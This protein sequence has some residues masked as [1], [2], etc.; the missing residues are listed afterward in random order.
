MLRKTRVTLVLLVL[1]LL[2][3]STGT[4]KIFSN[5]KI[6]SL[7]NQDRAKAGLKPLQLNPVLNLAAQAKAYDMLK[8]NYFD[9]A[10]PD[11]RLP[12]AWFKSMGYDYTYAGE[13][14]A[15]GFSNFNEMEDSLMASA[16]HRANILS[17]L[18]SDLGVGI[19]EYRGSPI[20]VQFF[21]ST[22]N[23]LT[24]RQ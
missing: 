14:L 6:L 20:V 16:N 17:P 18:Y 13:N 11:G 10:D 2:V 22:T 4:Q 7:V 21:G 8:Y 23:L 12:W 9:H 15:L 1:S 5:E 19:V 24:L 3:S